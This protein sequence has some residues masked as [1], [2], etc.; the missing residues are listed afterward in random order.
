MIRSAENRPHRRDGQLSFLQLQVALIPFALSALASVAVRL[1]RKKVGFDH[2]ETNTAS[3]NPPQHRLFNPRFLLVP[4]GGAVVARTTDGHDIQ[5]KDYR[6]GKRGNSPHAMVKVDG[7]AANLD[8]QV[9]DA[10]FPAEGIK[11]NFREPGGYR[12]DR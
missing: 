4:T 12:S 1:T 10:V 2:V 5:I 9:P 3:G 7:V 6:S 8:A 11:V